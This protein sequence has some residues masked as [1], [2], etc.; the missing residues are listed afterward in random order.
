[1][2]YSSLAVLFLIKFFKKS[3][4]HAPKY[5]FN[6]YTV[7]PVFKVNDWHGPE[8]ANDAESSKKITKNAT[9]ETACSGF[10][11]F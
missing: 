2:Y 4:Y 11:K 10:F 5:H 7:F 9:G 3:I 8:P 1:M 6:L